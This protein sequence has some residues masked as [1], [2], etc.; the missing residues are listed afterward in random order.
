M[1]IHQL[2]G[3]MQEMYLVE[4]TDK[5][6][7]LDGGCRCDVSLVTQF[8]THTLGRQLNELK[9]VVVTHMHPDHA[10]AAT[11]LRRITGCKIATASTEKH[12]YAG[13]A[14]WCE[15][16]T[17]MVLAH[18]VA[19]K[20]KKPF[21][22]LLYNPFFKADHF[23]H[24]NDLLPFFPDWQALATHGHT[25][26]DLTL[27]HA[28]TS[29]AYTADLIIKTRR[30]YITP[31]PVYLPKKYKA[32]LARVQSLKLAKLLLAHG[33][34]VTMSDAELTDFISKAPSSPKYIRYFIA[35][36]L[37]MKVSQKMQD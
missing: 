6:L 19:K 2:H 15:Y 26:R 5:L 29:T 20:L 12:W 9:L 30:G 35:E 4:Y 22:F 33:G 21:Q 36:K 18:Y 25:D 31:F 24:D 8:I 23:L 27:Y 17:D 13:I 34:K 10:G 32:S 7:L 14:G 11:K 3:Y 28:S 37:N 16:A 1:K